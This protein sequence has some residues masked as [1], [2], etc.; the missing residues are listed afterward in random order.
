MELILT[1]SAQLKHKWTYFSQLRIKEERDAFNLHFPLTP[2][3]YQLFKN[4][5]AAISK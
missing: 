2:W 3:S 4:V 5:S 1:Y